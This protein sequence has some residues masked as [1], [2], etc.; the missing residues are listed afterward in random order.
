MN[1]RPKINPDTVE[2]PP[3]SLLPL[4]RRIEQ[5]FSARAQR[6]GL[7]AYVC[8]TLVHLYYLQDASEPVSLANATNIPKQSMTSVLDYL[9]R[10]KLALRIPHPRDRRRKKIALTKAGK[11]KSAEMMKDILELEERALEK[12]GYINK[13]QIVAF[14][15]DYAET[16]EALIIDETE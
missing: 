13:E 3:L 16:L 11:A 15:T 2:I 4:W 10:E 9:E 8:I 1:R 12:T 14:L 5:A 6:S 7:P